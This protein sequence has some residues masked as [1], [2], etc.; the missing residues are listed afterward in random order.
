ML[1]IRRLQAL[2]AVAR[3]GSIAA[4]AKSLHFTAPAVS[5]QL[6]ALERETSSVLFHRTA[7]SIRLTDDGVLLAA[8]ANIVLSQLESATNALAANRDP[9]GPL[10]IAAFPTAISGLLAEALRALS[11]QHPAIVTTV[12]DAEPDAAEDLLRRNLVD[13]AITHHYDLVPRSRWWT[14]SRRRPCTTNRWCSCAP[15]G[16]RIPRPG[17]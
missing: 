4:A 12:L 13:V 8:H 10:R 14:W 7:R 17:R 11:M 9:A 16:R 5:Q 15:A 3:H 6:A 1:D 2:Q